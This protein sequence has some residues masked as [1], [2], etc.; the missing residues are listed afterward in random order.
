MSMTIR[1]RGCSWLAATASTIWSLPTDLGLS[2][3][4][5]M[6]VFMPEPTSSGRMPVTFSTAVKMTEF[7]GGTTEDRMA[8]SMSATSMPH[9]SRMF[10]KLTAY[11]VAVRL[12]SVVTRSIK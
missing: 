6:P 5:F 12:W 11:S 3:R 10:L 7:K 4:M 9:I 1:G 2:M 8:P